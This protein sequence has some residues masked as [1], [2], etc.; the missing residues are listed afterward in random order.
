MGPPIS[1]RIQALPVGTLIAFSVDQ[2]LT[3]KDLADLHPPDPVEKGFANRGVILSGR[4]PIWL[5]GFLVHYYHPCIYVALHDPRFEA[6]VVVQ[7]HARE[8][9]PGD[10][11]HLESASNQF[12]E[13][14]TTK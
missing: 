4:G 5:Y 1:F 8:Y 14:V 12:K 13:D 11:I 6:A 7:T 10:L 2:V 9:Q 3:P